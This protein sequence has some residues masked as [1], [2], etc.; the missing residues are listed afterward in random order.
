M[1]QRED[2][3]AGRQEQQ[4]LEERVRQEV[5]D[6]GRPRAHAERQEHVADLADGRVGQHPLDVALRQRAEAGQ[7][8]RQRRR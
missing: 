6:G 7:E 3:R 1:V 4:R 5:E 8:Q 2:D